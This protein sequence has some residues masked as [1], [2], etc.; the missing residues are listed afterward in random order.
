MDVTV[1]DSGIS[2]QPAAG[3]PA[4]RA[5]D[6]ERA[7]VADR[8]HNALVEGRLDVSEAEQRLAAVYPA[9]DRSDLPV[10][11]ADLPMPDVGHPGGGWA[12][13][14]RAVVDQAWMSSARIRGAAAAAP[15]ERQRRTVA[16]VLAA[17]AV[18]VTVCLLAGVALGVQA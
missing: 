12:A 5:S 18:W 16:I 2:E 15:D 10:L 8:V 13:V 6:A 17:A 14:W 7:A 11:L 1:E 4:V 3:G 9:R